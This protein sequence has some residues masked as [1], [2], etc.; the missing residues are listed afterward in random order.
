MGVNEDSSGH[1]ADP[2]GFAAGIINQYFGHYST[3]EQSASLW[4][5]QLG[6]GMWYADDALHCLSILLERGPA[7][8]KKLVNEATN[9][10]FGSGPHLADNSD[11]DGGYFEWLSSAVASFRSAFDA[12][13]LA[14]PSE[15]DED[16]EVIWAASA[17]EAEAEARSYVPFWATDVQINSED[18]SESY[19]E[20]AWNVT[21]RYVLP[22]R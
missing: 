4:A 9:N 10:T 7:G 22:Y 20:G 2:I 14:Y 11:D 12:A 21:T 3:P 6:T 1:R 19:G 13:V 15:T 5:N 8:L 16:E 17:A 18:F